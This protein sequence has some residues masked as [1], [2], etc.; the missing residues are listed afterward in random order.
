MNTAVFEDDEN[1]NSKKSRRGHGE[2]SL[3]WSESRQRYI[4]ELT[5]GYTPSGKRKVKKASDKTK[6]GAKKKLRAMMRDYE[7]GLTVASSGY[8]VADA[9]NDWLKFGRNGKDPATVELNRLH[10]NNHVI[11]GLGAR[12]LRDLTADDVDQW[13]AEKAKTLSTRTLADVL[14]VLTRS[15]KR[16]QARDKVKR[17]VALLC[18]VP[19]GQ[20]GRPSKSLTLPQATA[21]L[22]AVE[23]TPMNAY[24]VL[25]LL[26]GA[27]T[28]ELRALTWKH[29]DLIGAPD[30]KPPVPPTIEVW[31]SVRTDG[32]T[33]TRK[34]RRTLALPVRCVDALKRHGELQNLMRGRYDLPWTDDD[35]V[36]STKTG[37]ELDAA[38]VRRDFR[39]VLDRA[40]LDPDE[41]TPRELRHSFVSLLSDHGMRIEDISLLVGHS[42]TAVTELV[43]RHQLRP[44]L[45][46]GAEVMDD[47]F[48]SDDRAS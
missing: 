47:I 4:A 41:W 37:A 35:L 3:Y 18:D 19:T 38:H 48:P 10:A 12:K 13:L 17:N 23:P 8:T 36:F 43:Y 27:R 21:L 42:G 5:T 15:I 30:S 11:P 7:D 39:K 26:T 46:K 33:K 14:S 2:G 31:H 40:G 20:P 25:S 44:V 28:E 6:T 32:D 45:Q 34:S 1:E 29:V 9:V 22:K 24:I 16:A